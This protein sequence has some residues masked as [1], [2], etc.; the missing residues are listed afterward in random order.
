MFRACA[1]IFGYSHSIV[2][3]KV[4]RPA[5][6]GGYNLSDNPGQTGEG[7]SENH[8]FGRTSFVNA[9]LEYT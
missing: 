3:Q 4:G 9:P 7:G 1:C 5:G 8:D 6:G 2:N